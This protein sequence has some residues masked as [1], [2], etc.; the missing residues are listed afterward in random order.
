MFA[1]DS[2]CVSLEIKKKIHF[3]KICYKNIFL[4]LIFF[5]CSILPGPFQVASARQTCAPCGQG[6]ADEGIRKDLIVVFSVHIC[7]VQANET[8]TLASR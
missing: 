4:A 7:H 2:L 5:F 1:F 3:A 8:R 6:Q